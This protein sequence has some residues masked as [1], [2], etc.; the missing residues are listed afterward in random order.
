[1]ASSNIKEIMKRV[2]RKECDE[3]A[4]H[5]ISILIDNLRLK[6]ELTDESKSLIMEEVERRTIEH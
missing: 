1:M 5:I 4:L 2:S 3:N 6:G